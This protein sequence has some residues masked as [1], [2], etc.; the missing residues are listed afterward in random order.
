MSLIYGVWRAEAGPQAVEDCRFLESELEGWRR[1]A[2]GLESL[3]QASF[4]CC[5]LRVYPECSDEAQPVRG[6]AGRT[7]L[8]AD[9]R[10]DNREEL[11]RA[12]G[13]SDTRL[14]GLPD[15]GL[16]LAAY[17]SWGKECFR[18]L[19]GDFAVALWDEGARQLLLARDV[20]GTRPLAYAHFGDGVA[21]GSSVPALYRLPS[22]PRA[23]DEIALAGLLGG[24]ATGRERTLFA[25]VRWALPGALTV[26]A[27][28]RATTEV[29]ARLEPG[30]LSK[31]ERR[32]PERRMAELLEAS[33]RRRLRGESDVVCELSGGFDSGTVMALAARQLAGSGRA[34]RAISWA[35][36]PARLP[37]MEGP[38]ERR[39]IQW[40]ERR[41][42][43]RC[44]YFEF[45]GENGAGAKQL[46]RAS[47]REGAREAI[48]GARLIL[49]GWG[50][51]ECP[52][53]YLRGFHPQGL[54]WDG[55]RP[56]ARRLWGDLRELPYLHRAPL[57]LLRGARGTWNARKARAAFAKDRSS[58][59][60]GGLKAEWREALAAAH[61]EEILQDLYPNDTRAYIKRL[62]TRGHLEARS[63]SEQLDAARVG[64]KMAYPMQDPALQRFALSLDAGYFD[65]NSQRRRLFR[66]VT[67]ALG[68]ELAPGTRKR[69][70]AL[71]LGYGKDRLGEARP[72]AREA[73]A[74]MHAKYFGPAGPGALLGYRR[75][76]L[77]GAVELYLGK[78]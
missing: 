25:G 17:A 33:A 49:S 57:R 40:M 58:V 43:I 52:T 45:H 41:Y 10:L 60:K 73:E 26:F 20:S 28:G 19:E 69:E 9:C 51:D 44:A 59:V 3:G 21:F 61:G 36:D 35:P 77:R 75:M 24:C 42:G 30:S 12:L 37:L 56:A 64:A 29:I 7:L 31:E 16:I 13:F 18:R 63:A 67:A 11:G 66:Q 78:G 72:E 68:V 4:G 15:S 71:A 34:L 50:G 8:V 47:F 14:R 23:L 22:V 1:D 5:L 46:Y 39:Q 48:G 76:Q 62:L 32:A 65:Y 27:D 54:F 2:T 53:F 74:E 70:E 6:E 38:D 55:A